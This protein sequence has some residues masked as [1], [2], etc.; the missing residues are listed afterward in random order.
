MSTPI[1][2]VIT[3][4]ALSWSEGFG[5]AKTPDTGLLACTVRV[6]CRDEG[7]DIPAAKSG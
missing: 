7:A 5:L 4:G 2:I 6:L 3:Q 1:R